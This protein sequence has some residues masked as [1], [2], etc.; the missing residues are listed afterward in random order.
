MPSRLR[1]RAGLS[2]VE[3]VVALVIF[4]IGLLGVA[5]TLVQSASN[6]A[7]ISAQTGRSATLA[8]Q[9]SRLSALPFDSL[10]NAAG[11]TTVTT[12]PFRHTRCVA[13]INIA[14]GTGSTQVRL[15]ITPASAHLRADTLYL[16]RSR[17]ALPNPLNY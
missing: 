17:G 13:L 9:L 12:P 4:S 3:V 6:A 15:I 14:G 5:G 16:I 8:L 2:I 10:A 7:Q 1:A 11:C